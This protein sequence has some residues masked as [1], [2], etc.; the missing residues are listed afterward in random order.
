MIDKSDHCKGV[1]CVLYNR[2]TH[3]S[4]TDGETGELID[5]QNM[6]QMQR[7]VA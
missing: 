1:D 3:R 2:I 7:L 5:E 4:R 6:A